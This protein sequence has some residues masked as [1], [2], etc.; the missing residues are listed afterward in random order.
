M[1]EK[2]L[3]PL[4][5]RI[6]GDNSGFKKTLQDT[7]DAAAKAE[8]KKAKAVAKEGERE[9]KDRWKGLQMF[10]KYEEQKAKSRWK[11][12][13]MFLKYEEQ[14]TNATRAAYTKRLK[15]NSKVMEDLR[16]AAEREVKDRWRGLQM[17]LKYEEQKRREAQRTAE[18]EAKARWRGH[19]QYLKYE[20]Q[21][22]RE[23]E[24]TAKAAQQDYLKKLKFNSQVMEDQKKAEEKRV[25]DLEK[26]M[27]KS[28]KDVQKYQERQR[29]Q[30]QQAQEK[31]TKEQER[32]EDRRRKESQRRRM[33]AARQVANFQRSLESRKATRPD[34]G[35][36]LGARA[37]IYMHMNALRNL[38]QSG[39]GIL[40]LAG[41]YEIASIGI[42]AF[43]G[44]AAKAASVMQAIQDYAIAS[45]YQTVQ[46]ADMARNMMSYGI[47]ADDAMATLKGLGDVAG[48]SGL[49]LERLS[50]AMSQ[51][52]SM[53]RLQGQEL[54]QLTEQGFNPLE[55]IS[56]HTGK[57]ML[58]LK[59]IMEDGGISANA[60]REA[61]KVETSA[62]G[63]FAG[64]AARMQNSL[65]G[66]TNQ[67]KELAQKLGLDLVKA[68]DD[69]LKNALRR[70]IEKLKE[71]NKYINTPEGKEAVKRFATMA[72]NV[73][74]AA[75]AFHVIGLA[76]ATLRW[77][78]ASLA[79]IF[80]V[81]RGVLLP[82]YILLNLMLSPIGLL[83]QAIHALLTRSIVSFLSFGMSIAGTI[84]S[85][86][87]MGIAIAAIRDLMLGKQGLLE[88]FKSIPALLKKAETFVKGFFYN[89]QDNVSILVNWIR[90]NWDALSKY[91][92]QVFNGMLD[93]FLNN[94]VVTAAAMAKLFTLALQQVMDK[95]PGM[96]DKLQE[97]LS[98]ST[99][100]GD[101]FDGLAL[102]FGGISQKEFQDRSFARHKKRM[103][104]ANRLQQQGLAPGL[105]NDLV[106]IGKEWL[107]ALR[108]GMPEGGLGVDMPEFKLDIP[109]FKLPEVP[110]IELPEAYAPDFSDLGKGMS[111]LSKVQLLDT[112]VYDSADHARRIYEYSQ[113]ME[114]IQAGLRGEP[115]K[116]GVDKQ[117]LKALQGIEKN[118][119]PAATPAAANF[120]PS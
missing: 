4:Y 79:T 26:W 77:Q 9:A 25:K 61:L 57:S 115:Q 91:S 84:G 19:Q 49:R 8:A 31:A 95:I 47:A 48:G 112:A 67:I 58:E 80:S 40:E 15:F 66:L 113:N 41:N 39:R 99:V 118:T 45:P 71:F 64:M 100:T 6:L 101:F 81:F 44:S 16:K 63:R 12:V 69:D 97:A 104:N 27:N 24:K 38:T 85:I 59:K 33:D 5:V 10:L 74:V 110:K 34:M 105:A 42:E 3:P 18:A 96:V 29:K 22:R 94:V 114:A 73:L 56:R 106:G 86:G 23:A 83:A 62:G 75:M 109:E 32:N 72:K 2:E 107:A 37:D 92:E 46:L 89:F 65:P 30:A 51:I 52:T 55:T 78:V 108:H 53:S 111:S 35:F 17:F 82:V 60:V 103:D 102:S 50:F 68:I 70:A 116:E 117:Q 119:R 11:G 90:S 28:A 54:R 120:S 1:A 36:G 98:E 7:I 13:Q 88:S 87:A 93:A 21:K 20:E 76:I 14:K 43:T